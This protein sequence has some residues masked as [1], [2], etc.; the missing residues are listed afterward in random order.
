[1]D[2][3]RQFVAADHIKRTL[4]AADM[5]I[6]MINLSFSIDLPL[7]TGKFGQAGAGI[8]GWGGAAKFTMHNG[9]V[10]KRYPLYFMLQQLMPILNTASSVRRVHMADASVRFYEISSATNATH[11]VAWLDQQGVH[12]PGT[13]GK[14]QLVTLPVTGQQVEVFEPKFAHTSGSARTMVAK[15]HSVKLM[16]GPE[17]VYL[18]A[19]P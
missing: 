18:R 8:S 13:S 6:V 5:G 10:K 14:N 9:K 15:F 12:I 3:T 17:P 4:I 19:K 16:L 2:A 11:W 1:L 7:L